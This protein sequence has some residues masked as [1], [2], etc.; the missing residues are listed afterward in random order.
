MSH[1]E[2]P[3]T[4]RRDIDPI[5]LLRRQEMLSAEAALDRLHAGDAREDPEMVSASL[6]VAR[7][8]LREV[9]DEYADGTRRNWYAGGAS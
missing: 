1:H 6:V 8:K 3:K 2:N 9:D 5:L 7:K 4:L